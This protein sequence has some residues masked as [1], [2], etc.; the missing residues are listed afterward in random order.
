[1]LTDLQLRIQ[2]IIR[3]KGHTYS[4]LAVLW[5]VSDGT[6]KNHFRKTKPIEI[7]L[8][9]LVLFAQEYG[10]DL[11]F[12]LTG[13]EVPAKKIEE[14]VQAGRQ[15]DIPFNQ[16]DPDIGFLELLRPLFNKLQK[17]EQYKLFPVEGASMMTSIYPG[18]YL[19]CKK[20]NVN[21]IINGRVYVLI[22]NNKEMNQYRPSGRWVKRCYLRDHHVTCKSDNIDS[23]E[24]Y[25]TFQLPLKEITECWYPVFLF[26]G[27]LLDPNKDLYERIDQLEER[28]EM[29]ESL[30]E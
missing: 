30:N 25:I 18:D 4:N 23:S 26:T 15:Y 24:P 17:N 9:R 11:N 29:L 27:Q 10:V 28:I 5:G 1:M 8:E 14:A 6:V 22:T 2:E 20:D 13:Q 19:L 21:K 7:P 16:P 3:R 12:L